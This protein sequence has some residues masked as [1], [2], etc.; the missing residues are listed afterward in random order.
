[1]SIE[2]SE[3]DVHAT[4]AESFTRNGKP[5]HGKQIRSLMRALNTLQARSRI[6]IPPMA[7]SANKMVANV[8]D[9]CIARAVYPASVNGN[10][11]VSRWTMAPTDD[12]TQSPSWYVKIDGANATPINKSS[13]LLT[14]NVKCTSGS[15]TGYLDRF[16][17]DAEYEV[18]E[19]T[20]HEVELYRT[21]KARFGSWSLYEKEADYLTGA[22]L[23]VVSSKIATGLPITDLNLEYARTLLRSIYDRQQG[24]AL[25]VNDP[26]DAG[27][28]I[29]DAGV[30]LLRSRWVDPLESTS[31]KFAPVGILPPDGYATT[32]KYKAWVYGALDPGGDI[33]TTTFTL[34]NGG[35]ET[36]DVDIES[37]T[38]DFY[39]SDYVDI[40]ETA[41]VAHEID[42]EAST[43]VGSTGVIY[44]FGLM[45]LSYS[46]T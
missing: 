5:P 28:A 15:G 7:W 6:V 34:L 37:E 20:I 24:V 40:E 23:Y 46:A 10:R 17:I 32:Y 13:H 44:A 25:N 39:Y 27:V 31:Y 21:G 18:D 2:Y 41:G 9:G 43:D 36:F 38:P 30:N 29:D 8:A 19:D 11:L 16:V 1:M 12:D 14:H 4:I 22:Q 3:R 42:V 35:T 45:K 33:M 26:T